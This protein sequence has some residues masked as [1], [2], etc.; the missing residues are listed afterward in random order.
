MLARLSVG[1]YS[2]LERGGSHTPRPETLDAVADAL[3]MDEAMRADLYFLATENRPATPRRPPTA[4]GQAHWVLARASA[5]HP[6]M[7]TDHVAT[8][9]AYNSQAEDLF[10]D[11]D[12]TPLDGTNL[13]LWAF[14]AE[15]ARSVHGID[16]LRRASVARLKAAA[17]AYHDDKPLNDVVNRLREIP[18][19]ERLWRHE[20]ARAD[21]SV[22]LVCHLRR[23]RSAQDLAWTRTEWDDGTFLHTGLPHTG[24]SDLHPRA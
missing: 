16:A 11:A 5:P 12:C 21:R 4:A 6:A 13:F 20:R 19:A 3:L 15:A 2:Q 1:G 24:T 22:T 18:E 23:E 10:G 9:L 8:V 14:T 17:I 7:I